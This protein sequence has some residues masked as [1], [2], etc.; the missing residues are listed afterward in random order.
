M[1]GKT[2]TT[3]KAAAK[4]G[5]AAKAGKP[6]K[7]SKSSET[8]NAVKASKTTKISKA[9]KP[10]NA[11]KTAKPGKSRK[12]TKTAKPVSAAKSAK[13]GNPAK[14]AMSLETEVPTR[15][16]LNLNIVFA[17]A[18]GAPFSKSGGLGDVAGSL[19]KALAAAGARVAVVLPYYKSTADAFGDQVEHVTQ[20]YV[21]LGWRNEYC[22]LKRLRRD[23][24]DFYFIDNE[25]YFF[26][27]GF[28][29]YFDDGE[30]FA[31]FSKAITEC[32]Q[33][34]PDFRCDILHCNDWQTALAPI[35]LREFYQGLPAY[36]GIKTVFSIHNVKF[37]GKFGMKLLSDVTGLA[38][39]P[40][41]Q[42]QLEDGP[43]SMNFMKGALLYADKISTVSPT[44]A[45]E[46]KT[47][48]YGEG[49]DWIFRQRS[50]NLV[51]ILNGIDTD[52]FNPR[53]DETIFEC[54]SEE[55]LRRKVKDKE[56]LQRE[57]GLELNPTRPLVALVGR[58]TKQKGIDLVLWGLERLLTRSIQV[59]VLGTGDENFEQGLQAAAHAHPGEV[60]V[61]IAFDLDLSKRIYAGADMFL[62]PSLFE[63]CG[64][65]QM[66]SMRYGT[67]PVVRE[68]GGLKDSVVP[69]NQFT[70]EGTGFS[71]TNF[72]GDEM[73]NCILN[74]S[75]VFWTNQSAWENLQKQ[76]MIADFSW[77]SSAQRYI[78]MYQG[79]LS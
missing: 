76:A 3:V 52:A 19:P 15:P 2:K 47:P 33:Y 44:Y 39:I 78:D 35:F 16:D 28:Y 10:G 21:S 75:E 31:Y 24:V 22:G 64:L 41:A 58:L 61:R 20:F 68:T 1:T 14:T 74:A 60:A 26:R 42:S 79:L 67:L 54:Y 43:Q 66:I 65:A 57:L 51:G 45:E 59:V 4:S 50:D 11:A 48:F 56:A 55:N 27:D 40:A 7:T 73:V 62:M 25:H 34:L 71:F 8:D 12:G 17:S 70:G 30:R 63:P 72:N 77:G 49:L 38:G 23:N 46:L 13:S 29:G 5:N 53:T 32:I 9:A 37:Q 69:Y 18:E 36:E 6:A